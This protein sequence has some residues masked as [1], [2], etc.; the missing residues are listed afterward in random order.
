MCLT[1]CLKFTQ[2]VF[3]CHLGELDFEELFYFMMLSFFVC[4]YLHA[5]VCMFLLLQT[6][7]FVHVCGKQ[8]SLICN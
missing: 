1:F 3:F 2:S 7:M 6:H 4:V 8:T 5:C